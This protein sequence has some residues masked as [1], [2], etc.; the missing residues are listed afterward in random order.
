MAAV[1]LLFL[2]LG[3]I[4]LF[5]QAIVSNRGGLEY[6]EVSQY[7]TSRVEELLQLPFDHPLLEVTAADERVHGEYFSRADERWI[8]YDPSNDPPDPATWTRVTQIQDFSVDD[9]TTPLDAGAP[10]SQVHLKQITVTVESE[11]EAAGALGPGKSIR[12]RT[13][14]SQ[15]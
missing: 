12:V 13:Y 2:A 5:Q 11:R 6:T 7:A 15:G 3:M 14:K 9:L 4:P 10:P 8:D 1:V